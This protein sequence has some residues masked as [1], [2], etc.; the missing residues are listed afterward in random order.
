MSDRDDPDT[1]AYLET[2][3]ARTDEWFA[4]SAELVDEL[5]RDVRIPKEVMAVEQANTLL[6]TRAGFERVGPFVASGVAGG[7]EWTLRVEIGV[8][9]LDVVLVVE[10]VDQGQDLLRIGQ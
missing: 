7:M 9:L 2:E 3:N 8:N 6:I 5:R 4:E 1:V 10:G